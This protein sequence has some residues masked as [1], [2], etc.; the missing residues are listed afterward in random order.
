MKGITL[1][2]NKYQN[3][4]TTKMKLMEFQIDMLKNN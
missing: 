1:K 4:T 2:K 3:I